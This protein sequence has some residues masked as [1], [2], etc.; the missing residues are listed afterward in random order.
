M[1]FLSYLF[2]EYWCLLNISQKK[3]DMLL[4]IDCLPECF[5][6]FC[7]LSRHLVS[8]SAIGCYEWGPWPDVPPW[9]EVGWEWEGLGPS[10]S[11]W[12]ERSKRQAA[13]WEWTKEDRRDRRGRETDGGKVPSNFRVT[14]L[15]FFFF[16]VICISMY[17][18]YSANSFLLSMFL[19]NCSVSHF[20]IYSFEFSKYFIFLFCC[21][22]FIFVNLFIPRN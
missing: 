12:W 17:Q 13:D 14:Q 22:L 16:W 7:S 20:F 3:I 19:D 18:L 8:S 21:S 15:D 1:Y 2:K 4:A 6:G 5:L 10:F 11:C 9:G